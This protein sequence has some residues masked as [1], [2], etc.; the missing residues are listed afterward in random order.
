[1]ACANGDATDAPSGSDESPS[2]GS[3]SGSAAASSASGSTSS[4]GVTSGTGAGSDTSGSSA[5]TSGD[6]EAGATSGASNAGSVVAS[7]TVEAGSGAI[8]ADASLASSVSDGSAPTGF[9]VS[10]EVG[11]SAASSA[12]LGCE[13]SVKNGGTASAAVS[14]L[15]ARYYFTDEVHLA[16]QMTINWS[17]VTTSGANADMTVT[18]AFG[19]IA[20]AVPEA[21]SYIEFSFS[22]AHAALAPGEAIVFSW[23]MQGPDPS[24]DLYTQSNDYSF[25]ASKTSLTTWNHVVLLDAGTVVWGTVP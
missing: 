9:S 25:D 13:L 15:K 1:M 5:A 12:Y 6:V 19:A 7:A 4:G 10:Y 18:A 8:A 22:S 3:T 24:K 17:H 16:R 14:S 23:Q 21:D 20:P 11:S 2:G